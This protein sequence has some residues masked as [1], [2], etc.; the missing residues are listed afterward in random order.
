M[1]L[2]TLLDEE[3][4]ILQKILNIMINR[5]MSDGNKGT[6]TIGPLNLYISSFRRL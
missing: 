5:E 6:L 4:W 2:L 1:K 3:G